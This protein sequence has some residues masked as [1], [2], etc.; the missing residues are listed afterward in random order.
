[1]QLLAGSP[2]EQREE[3]GAG[4]AGLGNPGSS[5]NIVSANPGCE[6]TLQFKRSIFLKEIKKKP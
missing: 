3:K 1:L 4:R 6:K 5:Y 2:T